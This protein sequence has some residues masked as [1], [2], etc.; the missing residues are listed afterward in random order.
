MCPKLKIL[1]HFEIFLDRGPYGTGNF[2]MLLLLQF[3]S[4]VSQTLWGHWLPWW[5]TG[6]LL[7]FLAI[8]QFLKKFWHFEI[9]TWESVWKPKMW[10][11][12]KTVYRRAKRTKNWDSGSPDSLSLVWGHSM[13]NFRFYDIQNATSPTIF[14]GLHPN[15]MRTLLTMGG[16]RLLLFLAINQVL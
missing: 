15:F 13:Q 9:L 11:I 8:G 3:S 2:K 10:N 16:C 4:D 6:Y 14:I 5:N 1:W 12:S 7:P